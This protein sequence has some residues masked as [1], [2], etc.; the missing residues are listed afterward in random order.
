MP[1]DSMLKTLRGQVPLLKIPT[2]NQL[3]NLFTKG[4]G[5]VAFQCLQK[6]LMGW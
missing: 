2:A 1:H 6:E 4:L 3:G 5:C